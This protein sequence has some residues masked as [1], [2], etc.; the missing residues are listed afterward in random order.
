M[1]SWSSVDVAVL[2]MV[3][4]VAVVVR[5]VPPVPESRV[6]EDAAI[7]L[8]MVMTSLPVEV[9]VVPMFIVWVLPDAVLPAPMAMVWV[10]VD[11]PSV[12][13]PV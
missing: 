4:A 1:A 7:V 11:W 8:P 9:A 6:K 10:S 2:K 3:P 12:K 13:V 5:V